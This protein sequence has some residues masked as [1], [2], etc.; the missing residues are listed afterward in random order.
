MTPT[1]PGEVQRDS[2]DEL[3]LMEEIEQAVTATESE[4]AHGHDALHA[5]MDALRPDLDPSMEHAVAAVVWQRLTD[6]EAEHI[7]ITGESRTTAAPP[8]LLLEEVEVAVEAV[9]AEGL[10]GRTARVEATRRVAEAM[11]DDADHARIATE[12]RARMADAD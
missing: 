5:V 8:V 9:Q 3:E 4:G 12:V 2:T 1:K 10:T 7:G 6:P 11:G